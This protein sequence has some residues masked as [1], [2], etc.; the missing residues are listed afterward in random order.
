MQFW[1]AGQTFP[2]QLPEII[3]KKV[4]KRCNNYSKVFSS[5]SSHGEVESSL[6]APLCFL[7]SRPKIFHSIFKKIK[8]CKFCKKLSP[9]S[10]QWN[11]ES[12][13]DN[14]A[15]FFARIGQ[16][17]CSVSKIEKKLQ[18]K[19]FF[20]EMFFWTRRMQFQPP[21]RKT[22]REAENLSLTV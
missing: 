16:K 11:W 5:K 19:L 17:N 18:I 4:H 15:T 22:R 2:A 13:F 9:E 10:F 3:P 21:C 20:V 7:D 14:S 8:I 12:S 6:K 1:Q